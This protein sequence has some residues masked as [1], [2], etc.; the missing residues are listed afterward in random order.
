MTKEYKN[1]INGKWVAS[2]SGEIF[3]NTNPANC[4]E[5]LGRFQKS[6]K[7]DV[8]KAVAAA[9]KAKKMWRETPAPKRGEIMYKVAELLVKH[10]ESLAQ[11]MTKEMGKIIAET[12]GDVQEAIDLTYFAAGEGRR[13]AGETVPSELKNK[14]AMSVRMPLGVVACVTPWNFPLAIPSWKL[15]PALICG[16][17]A[18]IK[19]AEDTPLTVV[20]FMNIFE[21][22]GLPPGVV[23]MV[24][25]FG[26]DAGAPLVE[27]KDV[28]MV[29]FTGS[30]QTG[31]GIASACAQRMKQYSLEMGGKNAIIIMDDANLSLALEG[32]MFG[33]FGTTGQ[34]CTACSRVVIHKKVAKKFTDMLVER[35]K[36]LK[37]GNGLDEK[38]DMGPLINDKAREKVHRYVQIGKDE[39]A[40]LLTGGNYANGKVLKNG[41]FY[42]P[43][44]FADV[45]SKMR[46]AQE[47]IFGPVVGVIACSSFEEAVDI[48]N[49]SSYGLS[50]AIYT[51]DVNRAFKAIETLET[52][53]T[54]VNASTIGAEIQ[55]PFGGI[56]GTGNGHREVGIA[57]L[58]TFSEWKSVFVDYSG[59]LQKAQIDHD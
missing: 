45:D 29:S 15:I 39:G 9:A 52:G 6:N 34:R 59:K 42:Q 57:A 47:E 16:N 30:T 51:Q 28:D 5:V 13:M 14:F 36:K 17:T 11:D 7:K 24:T 40:K 41:W 32:V 44:V 12:R 58:E 31:A 54:Y 22:A 35:A 46:I 25:G 48:V 56:K 8:D 18:V 3:E 37:L 2:S 21:K 27:H 20:N 23:N 33:A 38:V 49:D 43:T 53:L 26:P 1:Y 55:L 50:S 19:P 10:K 4:N